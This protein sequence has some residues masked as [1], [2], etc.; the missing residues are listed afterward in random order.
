MPNQHQM[1]NVG[2]PW[3]TDLVILRS[4]KMLHNQKT[5]WGL[6]GRINVPAMMLQ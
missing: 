2:K 6:S 1:L 4:K 5:I 3:L